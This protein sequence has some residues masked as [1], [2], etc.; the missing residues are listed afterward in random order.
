[1]LCPKCYARIKKEQV[2]CQHC[3]FNLNVM[4]GATNK[5]AKIAKKTIYK[6]DILY[7]TNVP[8]DVSKKSYCCFQYFLVFLEFI[9]FTLV[10]FGRVFICAYAQA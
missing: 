10:S 9:I 6:D 7:T 3:G 4:Q 5:E 1:M 2:R 8:Q